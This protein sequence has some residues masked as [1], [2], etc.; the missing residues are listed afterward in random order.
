MSCLSQNTNGEKVITLLTCNNVNGKRLIVAA[1]ENKKI[2]A[3]TEFSLQ[4][5]INN[6]HYFYAKLLTEKQKMKN[7]VFYFLVLKHNSSFIFTISFNNYY[8]IFIC[9]LILYFLR[10]Y[11]YNTFYLF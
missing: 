4:L 5:L 2:N 10:F 9:F 1:K 8:V 7:Y 6:L 11:F 3:F